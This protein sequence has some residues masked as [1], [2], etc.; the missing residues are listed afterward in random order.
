MA[1]NPTR[2][3]DRTDLERIAV[4]EGT[5]ILA[6]IRHDLMIA[7]SDESTAGASRLT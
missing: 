7:S 6:C 3:P 5:V 4:F 1:C 2:S